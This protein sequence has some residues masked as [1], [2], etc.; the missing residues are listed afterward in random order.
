[1]KQFY[2]VVETVSSAITMLQALLP[3]SVFTCLKEIDHQMDKLNTAIDDMS[4]T[5]VNQQLAQLELSQTLV[6]YDILCSVLGLQ[7]TF[8]QFA[9]HVSVDMWLHDLQQSQV[10]NWLERNSDNESLSQDEASS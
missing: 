5:F 4:F 1:M 7:T 8:S 3:W 9:K 10:V 6:V 2:Q